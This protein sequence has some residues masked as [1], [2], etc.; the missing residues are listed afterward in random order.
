MPDLFYANL[1]PVSTKAVT[2]FHNTK[3]V[4]TLLAFI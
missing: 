2:G 4:D 1:L 3:P